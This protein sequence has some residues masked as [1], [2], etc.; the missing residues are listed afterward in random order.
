MLRFYIS[1]NSK[2]NLNFFANTTTDE[3]QHIRCD[4]MSLFMLQKAKN[5]EPLASCCFCVR[6][7]VEARRC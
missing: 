3:Q 4:I 7:S 6:G 5:A 1:E 2:K